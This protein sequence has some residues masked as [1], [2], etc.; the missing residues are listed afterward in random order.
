MYVCINLGFYVT[1]PAML[2]CFIENIAEPPTNKA[3]QGK[4]GL[5]TCLNNPA[6]FLNLLA[7]N[8]DKYCITWPYLMLVQQWRR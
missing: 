6:H 2:D 8:L 4:W 7:L 3:K 5:N 1:L